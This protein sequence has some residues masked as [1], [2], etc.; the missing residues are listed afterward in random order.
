MA[1]HSVTISFENF[2]NTVAIVEVDWA[3]QIAGSVL[4]DEWQVAPAEGD[5]V[6]AGV[7]TRPA[8]R[9]YCRDAD[10]LVVPP[11][12]A[13]LIAKFR[14]LL[15]VRHM[16]MTA[17]GAK[18]LTATTFVVPE[19]YA[20]SIAFR[21]HIMDASVASLSIPLLGFS[22]GFSEARLKVWWALCE[23]KGICS[24]APSTLKQANGDMDSFMELW[25]DGLGFIA[26]HKS[27]GSHFTLK[28]P[29]VLRTGSSRWRGAS[30]HGGRE[31]G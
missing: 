19:P 21:L 12:F 29:V 15:Q 10:I 9:Q 14:P 25:K 28:K 5:I 8:T 23:Q 20:K 27:V 7:D 26:I 24:V 31:G 17:S 22:M 13:I 2:E 4:Y 30:I 11:T 1:S 3:A 18:V 6:K 16:P